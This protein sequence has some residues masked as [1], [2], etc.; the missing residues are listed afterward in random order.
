MGSIA[1][2]EV[3]RFLEK[4]GEVHQE[5]A[6]LYLIGGG[7]LCLL[8]NP[9]RTADIDFSLTSLAGNKSLVDSMLAVADELRIELEVITLEEFVPVPEGSSQRH[10]FVRRFGGIELFIYDPYAIALS[11]LARGLETDIQDVLFLLEAEIIDIEKLAYFV[12]QALPVA[13]EKDV[14]PDDLKLYLGEV[15]KLYQN[16]VG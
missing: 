7:A 11:K 14:D 4:L 13:W 5:K 6:V 8:G 3:M 15:R 2:E 12:E 10:I 1:T 9:R 16:A